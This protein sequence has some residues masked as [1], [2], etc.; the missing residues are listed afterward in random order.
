[1]DKQELGRRIYRI[2]HLTGNFTLRSGIV[3]DE[4]F[5]KYLFESDPL[6]LTELSQHLSELVPDGTEV[7]A[8]LE[9]GGIPLATALSL[10]TGIPAAFVRKKAKS[11]GTKN[12]A[13]GTDVRD[14]KVCIIEDVTST[15]GQIIESANELRKIGANVE[16]AICVIVRDEIAIENLASE[17]IELRY[18]FDMDQL[19]EFGTK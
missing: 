9:L 16:S 15:A 1:M 6:L 19:Y 13:E 4:Y 3:S 12:L 14:K 2:S 10:E 11:Y 18:L 5:D 7:L 17:G 8:G